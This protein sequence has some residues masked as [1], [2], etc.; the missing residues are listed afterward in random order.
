M[1]PIHI[2]TKKEN[3]APLVLMPGDPLRAK[4]IAEKYLS[5]YK[6]INDVRNM[7]GYTGYYKKTKVTVIGSG[8]GIPSASLYAMELYKFYDVQKII[9]IGSAGSLNENIHVRDIIL[10]TKA[11]SNSNFGYALNKSKKKII[12]STNSLNQVIKKTADNLNINIKKGVIYTSE[13]F[14]V[15]ASIDHLLNKIPKNINLL[16]SEMEAFGILNVANYYQKEAT[17]LISISDS[18]F[19]HTNDLTPEERQQ[20]LDQMIILAL[21]SITNMWCFLVTWKLKIIFTIISIDIL[22]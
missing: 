17:C 18:K 13:V 12:S 9:R 19:N 6:L 5:D 10:C 3:I 2:V 20:S 15:Y 21:E 11:Y 4:Y 1:E 8:M 16:A 14:D 7:L 22:V